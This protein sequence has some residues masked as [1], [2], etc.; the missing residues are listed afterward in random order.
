MGPFDHNKN[1]SICPRDVVQQVRTCDPFDH[2]TCNP[3]DHHNN[4]KN[5][6]ICP[7]DV[8]QQ[9]RTCDPFDHCTWDPFDHHNNNNSGIFALQCSL[10][11]NCIESIDDDVQKTSLEK[12]LINFLLAVPTKAMILCLDSLQSII[13][14]SLMD[15]GLQVII[16]DLYF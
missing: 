10:S 4:K 6:S 12:A 7:R 1:R 2:C 13:T 3:F 5:R 8:V 11:I 14:S 15:F 9:V 16:I